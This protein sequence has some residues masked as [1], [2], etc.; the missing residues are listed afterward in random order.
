MKEKKTILFPFVGDSVGGSQI[1]TRV[2]I[3]NLKSIQYNFEVLIFNDSGDL[4]DYFSKY[5]YN[6]TYRNKE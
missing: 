5:K 2:L 6:D 1:A 4:S 3:N